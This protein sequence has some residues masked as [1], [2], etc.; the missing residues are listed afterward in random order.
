VVVQGGAGKFVALL[1]LAGAGGYAYSQGY[2]DQIL[3]GAAG[4]NLTAPLV[5]S[6]H[7]ADL[8]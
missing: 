8:L 4:V 3:G 5:S 7:H 1:G 2:L 6:Q